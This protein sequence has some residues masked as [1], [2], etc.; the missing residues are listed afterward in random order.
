MNQHPPKKDTPKKKPP[1]L[2]T[3]SSASKAIAP[4]RSSSCGLSRLIHQYK[5][6]EHLAY[7]QMNLNGTIDLIPLLS[8]SYGQLHVEFKIGSK[9]KYVLKNTINFAN[10]M[11]R[12]E[13]VS[14]GKELEFYH[15]P[16]AF[17]PRGRALAEFL[18]VEAENRSRNKQVYGSI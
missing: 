13:S 7:H 11:R 8:L 14:Y 12:G 18:M 10:A 5:E 17:T 2:S 6:T 4:G 1:V 16:E 9:R 15:I 3:G